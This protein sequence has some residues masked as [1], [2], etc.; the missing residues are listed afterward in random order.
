MD[1]SLLLRIVSAVCAGLVLLGIYHFFPIQGLVFICL[2]AALLSLREF[3]RLL[4]PGM[5]YPGALFL[6]SLIGLGLTIALFIFKTPALASFCLS[7]SLYFSGMIIVSREKISNERLLKDLTLGL[8]SFFYCILAPWL[9][10]QLI[11]LPHGAAWFLFLLL[12]VF[13]GDTFAFFGGSLFGKTK[14]NP[15]LSPKK[16]VEGALAGI[17]GS[18]IASLGFWYFAR[19]DL[20]PALLLG[21]GAVAG[22]VGQTGDLLMSLIKR[23]AQVKDSGRLLPGH[24][25]VLDRI[26]GV[27][28]V[29]PLLYTLATLVH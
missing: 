4:F 11:P 8:F 23:V 9:I 18:L 1:K 16:T 12:V 2:A 19:P 20:S 7:A 14:L 6:Y 25:G 22:A 10:S 28:L 26:D 13:F 15:S 3:R 27:L 17:L 5:E 24:G 21:F 29:C